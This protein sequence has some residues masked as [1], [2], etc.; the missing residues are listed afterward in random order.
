MAVKDAL[1]EDHKQKNNKPSRVH[2]HYLWTFFMHACNDK[3]QTTFVALA[4]TINPINEAFSKSTII[5]DGPIDSLGL[6][7]HQMQHE[8]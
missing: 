6:Y 8:C 4:T 5:I 7:L 3:D 1:V 2:S